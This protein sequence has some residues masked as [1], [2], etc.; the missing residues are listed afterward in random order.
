MYFAYRYYLDQFKENPT[1][2][3]FLGQK[4]E[5]RVQLAKKQ[6]E[7]D[8]KHPGYEQRPQLTPEY[9][10]RDDNRPRTLVRRPDERYS[11]PYDNSQR[12]SYGNRGGFRG[13]HGRGWSVHFGDR[14]GVYVTGTVEDERETEVTK[15][16]EHGSDQEQEPE[17]PQPA[18]LQREDEN[19]SS[20]NY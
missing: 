4:T 5:S 7:Y 14:R 13:R 11:R 15:T 3:Q 8:G 18:W 9:P 2:A 20:E 16:P 6:A 12:G 19:G 10:R 1:L 17:Q